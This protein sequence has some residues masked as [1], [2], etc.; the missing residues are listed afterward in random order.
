MN[1]KTNR[2]KEVIKL[3][4][5]AD[6]EHPQ[7]LHVA[8]AG[9]VFDSNSVVEIVED[10]KAKL[11][12]TDSA[13]QISSTIVSDKAVDISIRLKYEPSVIKSHEKAVPFVEIK[14]A[15]ESLLVAGRLQKHA[16]GGRTEYY[17]RVRYALFKNK[18]AE[19]GGG[20]FKPFVPKRVFHPVQHQFKVNEGQMD[21]Y[22]TTHGGST[23]RRSDSEN[24]EGTP[25]KDPMPQNL[26]PACYPASWASLCSSYQ[27]T[28]LHP[29]RRWELGTPN[30]GNPPPNEFGDFFSTW[31]MGDEPI[32]ETPPPA[33]RVED[34]QADAVAPTPTRGEIVNQEF[35]LEDGVPD[36][37]KIRRRAAM[38][39]NYLLR[40]VGGADLGG[41]GSISYKYKPR[42]VSIRHSGHAW[43]IVG[44]D[45]DGFWAHAQN[46]NSYRFSD[47]CLWEHARW[48]ETE[49]SLLVNTDP[50]V[51]PHQSYW[52]AYPKNC[53]LKPVER[54]L[55]SITLQ[56]SGDAY[57]NIQF[58]GVNSNISDVDGNAVYA[59]NWT[60]HVQAADT[61]YFWIEGNVPLTKDGFP[62]GMHFFP[63]LGRRIP[64][65]A[66]DF[67]H[68]PHCDN[69]DG[70]KWCRLRLM[71]PFWVH[72]TTLDELVTY[73]VDLKFWSKDQRWV[74]LDA[75]SIQ[76]W[77][78]D[79][80]HGFAG[81]SD[82]YSSLPGPLPGER[83]AIQAESETTEEPGRGHP[84]NS[85]PIAWY[86]DFHRDQLNVDV[87]HGVRLVLTCIEA[88]G[89][90]VC[91]VQDIKQLWF[92]VTTPPMW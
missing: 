66:N 34:W 84:M 86:I 2:V 42:P 68:C 32:G 23:C 87:V 82:H 67:G 47:W 85:Q 13:F 35:R 55:G 62:E 11:S 31:A 15:D 37:G 72:N 49:L 50:E 10:P 91:L 71:L 38:I 65:P 7:G 33:S 5:E 75:N 83:F 48:L 36:E 16:V 30:E 12:H 88:A 27:M 74:N 17:V 92:R 40:V 6:L 43:N 18:V 9:G 81:V 58:L 59:I 56:G 45:K 90:P 19:I 1:A 4:Q 69:P 80:Y 24:G 76:P 77:P 60:P 28:P 3:G 57:K 78:N 54:R 70:C 61:G 26:Y 20:I 8:I 25:C 41:H 52:V 29:R 63:D 79:D 64:R 73:K 53:A 89:Q 51:N 46:P 14:E 22:A 44:V 21:K 39:K